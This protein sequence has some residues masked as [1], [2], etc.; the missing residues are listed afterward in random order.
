MCLSSESP[1]TVDHCHLAVV[2]GLRVSGFRVL[3]FRV[4]GF[5]G[6]RVLGGSGF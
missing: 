3:D 5:S 6:F 4:L 1:A 2:S